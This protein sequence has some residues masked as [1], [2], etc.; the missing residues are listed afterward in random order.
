VRR[1]VL[2]ALDN[3]DYPSHLLRERLRAMNG[4]AASPFFQVSFILQKPHRFCD[5][6]AF[7]VD[8]AGPPIDLGGLSVKLFG[9]ERRHARSELE[10][11]MID[12]GETLSGWLHYNVE[13]FDPSTIARFASHFHRLLDCLLMNPQQRLSMQQFL[14]DAEMKQQLDDWSNEHHRSADP[15]CFHQRF[16]RQAEQSPDKIAAVYEGNS[17]TFKELNEQSDRLADLIRDLTK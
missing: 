13:L 12:A 7:L 14:A 15:S 5:A 11:E 8:Q 17:W 2:C 10:L 1:T 6:T 16:A 4:A 9:L 3:Q